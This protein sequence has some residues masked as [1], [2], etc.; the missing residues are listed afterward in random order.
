MIFKFLEKPVTITAIISEENKYVND[1]FPIVPSSKFIPEWWKNTPKSG[2]NI[3][4]FSDMRTVKSCMGIIGTF[5]TGY[6][7][8]LWTDLAFRYYEQ[9]SKGYW[10][11]QAS[12]GTTSMDFHTNKQIPN[13][14]TDSLFFKISSPWMFISSQDL[15]YCLNDPFYTTSQRRPYYIPYGV[16]ES[17]N[18]FMKINIFLM[19]KREPFNLLLNSGMPMM[20]IVPITEKPIIFKTEVVSKAEWANKTSYDGRMSFGNTGL[21]AKKLLKLRNKNG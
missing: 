18:N 7:V 15:K 12:D 1:Y 20:H 13:F 21:L 5:Q 19:L 3:E 16:P 4:N 8:P 14:Y 2:W 11:Y 10:E 6:I 17:I 9:E